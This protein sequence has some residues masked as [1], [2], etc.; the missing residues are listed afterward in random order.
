MQ[1]LGKPSDESVE[2]IAATESRI[3]EKSAV[4]GG[5]IENQGRHRRHSNHIRLLEDKLNQHK[6]R[7]RNLKEKLKRHLTAQQSTMEELNE[8]L[9]I[10]LTRRC[11][12]MWQKSKAE[13]QMQELEKSTGEGTQDFINKKM[14][15][16]HAAKLHIF[17]ETKLQDA[18]LIE[19]DKYKKQLEPQNG[20]GS[21]LQAH[22]TLVEVTGE[23]DPNQIGLVSDILFLE[24]ENEHQDEQQRSRLQELKVS[25]VV[26]KATSELEKYSCLAESLEEQCAEVQ[27]VLDLLTAAISSLFAEIMQNSI[28]VLADNVVNV[29]GRCNRSF[30]TT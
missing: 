22:M 24:Q 27:T 14:E 1:K 17:M 3:Q 28:T 6:I 11:S 21:D 7:G 18:V 15:L 13:T 4:P 16:Q 8:K 30:L 20:A 12:G 2:A 26:S 25:V 10:A 29:I 9:S 19:E 23:T 5:I